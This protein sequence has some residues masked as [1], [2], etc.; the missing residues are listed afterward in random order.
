MPG[1]QIG[2]IQM[3]NPSVT[4]VIA[5]LSPETMAAAK[6]PLS[7]AL[8]FHRIP[9]GRKRLQALATPTGRRILERVRAYVDSVGASAAMPLAA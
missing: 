2:R 4:N 7:D 9:S 1:F 6:V 5:P 8:W 3:S